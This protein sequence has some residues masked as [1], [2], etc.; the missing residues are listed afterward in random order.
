[1]NNSNAYAWICDE[2]GIL[3]YTNSLFASVFNV[4]DG[5]KDKHISEV[6]SEKVAER[7]LEKNKQFLESSEPKFIIVESE[8]LDGTKRKI[9]FVSFSYTCKNL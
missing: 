3:V 1:M 5:G 2:D 7:F 4:T 9:C 6:F 8:R